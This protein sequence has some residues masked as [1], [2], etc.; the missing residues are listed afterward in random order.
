MYLVTWRTRNH[1]SS[2]IYHLIIFRYIKA[3]NWYAR[4]YFLVGPQLFLQVVNLSTFLFVIYSNVLGW[5]AINYFGRAESSV[6]RSSYKRV[7]LL[8][9]EFEINKPLIDQFLFMKW[10]KIKELTRR[11]IKNN[12]LW[13]EPRDYFLSIK[14]LLIVTLNRN[15]LPNVCRIVPHIMHWPI[16]G[17]LKMEL[18]IDLLID[19]LRY[20][21]QVIGEAILQPLL[22]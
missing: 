19:N 18:T 22:L 9:S 16:T 4:S 13:L 12:W 5:T 3:F 21:I 10:I 20:S 11:L 14:S 17:N 2:C 7:F 8:S 15:Q 1:L 6:W